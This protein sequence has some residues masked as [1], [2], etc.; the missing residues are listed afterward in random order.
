M[1]QSCGSSWLP[2]C[3][4]LGLG[5]PLP[6]S[7]LTHRASREHTGRTLYFGVTTSQILHGTYLKTSLFPGFSTKK[8]NK[9]ACCLPEI[10][11]SP[12]ALR[13]YLLNLAALLTAQLPRPRLVSWMR[14]QPGG[15]RG[16][17]GGGLGRGRGL[18]KRLSGLSLA[19][20]WDWGQ[21]LLILMSAFGCFSSF[22]VVFVPV[23]LCQ[24][25]WCHRLPVD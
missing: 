5:C 21:M 6:F 15:G 2:C 17:P 22:L 12:G 11:I 16:R 20:G 3:P 7:D 9:I 18:P 10:Q 19:R 1:A 14:L 4:V 13:F 24:W 23:A 8:K 25:W